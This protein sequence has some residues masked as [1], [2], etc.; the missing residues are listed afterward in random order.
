MVELSR[1][2]AVDLREVWKHE[3]SD[4]TPWLADNID[5]L[6]ACS[7]SIWR[8]K[9]EKPPWGPSLWTCSRETSAA[10]AAW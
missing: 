4:F 1:L 3:A 7:A 2:E 9:H 5:E 8:S 10:I 6:G